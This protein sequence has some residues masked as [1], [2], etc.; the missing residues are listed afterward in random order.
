MSPAYRPGRRIV[1]WT[2][3]EDEQLERMW[4]EGAPDKVIARAIGRTPSSIESR[5]EYLGMTR[6]RPPDEPE[7]KLPSGPD[8]MAL[9]NKRMAALIERNRAR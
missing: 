6:K 7:R 1:K 2:A 9:W 4:L 5:R 3:E 8:L